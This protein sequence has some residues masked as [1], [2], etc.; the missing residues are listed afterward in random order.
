[1]C[2]EKGR[3]SPVFDFRFSGEN[4]R[5]RSMSKAIGMVE[6]LTVSAGIQ[7]ADM[8]LKTAEVE[9]VESQP[10]CPGKYIV[11]IT[12]DLSAVKASVD[13]VKT[14]FESNLMGSFVLGNPHE[15]LFPALYGASKVEDVKALGVLETFN[16]ADII[17]AADAAAKTSLVDLIELRV[18]RGMC[19]NPTCSSPAMLRRSAPRST[20]QSK[21]SA[22]TECC[23]TARSSPTRTSVFGIRSFKLKPKESCPKG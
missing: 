1:M 11:I 20:V 12:G 17:S 18:A 4:L 15:S 21:R 9:V 6:L 23:S 14:R 7:S 5:L 8:M 22:P 16:A 3:F 2:G 13:S 19:G 10:V